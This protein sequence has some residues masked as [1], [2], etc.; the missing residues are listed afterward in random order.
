VDSTSWC[1]RVTKF[2]DREPS[3]RVPGVKGR[4]AGVRVLWLREE[5]CECPPDDDEA[6]VTMYTRAWVWHMFA[7]VLFPDSTGDVAS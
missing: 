7:T 2:I 5:F 6:T 3:A 4:E 1:E